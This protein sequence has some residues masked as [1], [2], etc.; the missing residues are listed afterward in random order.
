MSSCCGTVVKFTRDPTSTR[1]AMPIPGFTSNAF[2]ATRR[3]STRPS[4]SGTTSR[5]APPT[6]SYA[7]NRTFDSTCMP[8][9]AVSVAPEISSARSYFRRICHRLR[10]NECSIIYA[11][12][13]NRR[14]HKHPL[15]FGARGGETNQLAHIR[16]PV[17]IAL[18]SAR[19][20]GVREVIGFPLALLQLSSARQERKPNI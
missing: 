15:H 11:K 13:N 4:R 16:F 17:A 10:G 18:S 2:L 7:T 8:A 19:R 20:D 5:G 14:V 9:L 12:L 6:A 3:N 1:S